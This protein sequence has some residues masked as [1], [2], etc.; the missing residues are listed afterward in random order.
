MTRLTKRLIVAS[1][2]SLSLGLVNNI[3]EA[4]SIST[5]AAVQDSI[6]N[7]R[8][9]GRAIT[10]RDENEKA[11]ADIQQWIE[12]S[13]AELLELEREHVTTDEDIKVMRGELEEIKKNLIALAKERED[14][15]RRLE[16]EQAAAAAAYD[17]AA[18]LQQQIIQL[19]R[20]IEAAQREADR[21]NAGDYNV[22]SSNGMLLEEA[23]EKALEAVQYD[24]NRLEEAEAMA[25][26]M[27]G[28]ENIDNSDDESGTAQAAADSRLEAAIDRFDDAMTR[29]DELN[30][31]VN[32]AEDTMVDY[33]EMLVDID[34]QTAY[35]K[36]LEAAIPDSESYKQEL[37]EYR[38]TVNND[39]AELQRD[40][41][42]LERQL[43][44]V[45]NSLTAVKSMNWYSWHNDRGDK[46]HQLYSG[47]YASLIRNTNTEISLQTGIVND[48]YSF[49]GNS[50]D[51]KHLTDTSLNIAQT[52]PH[53]KYNVI[54][55]L[56]LT[57][58]TGDSEQGDSSV[59]V[60]D[61]LVEYDTFG[62]GRL[63]APAIS[64]QRKIGTEDMWTYNLGY[65]FRGDYTNTSQHN[66]ENGNGINTSIAWQHIEEEWQLGSELIFEKNGDS[67]SDGLDYNDGDNVEFHVT[68]NNKL[69]SQNDL[70]YFY[71]Y[72]NQDGSEYKSPVDFAYDSNGQSRHY[73]GVDF[74]RAF[75]EQRSAHIMLTGMMGRGNSYDAA[76]NTSMHALKRYAM[77]A[78]YEYIID[79]NS[80]ISL[81]IER[82]YLKDKVDGIGYRGNNVFFNYLKTF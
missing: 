63:V 13:E 5:L 73:Y 7:L 26:E 43:R 19:Q 78:G 58:P 23:Y 12:E 69:T 70:A 15:A 21:F 81:D 18:R 9:G 20:E 24:E 44:P 32:T 36:E 54:Y 57:L 38:D 31:I 28:L 41:E 53:D 67:R 52:N 80:S 1:V 35:Q 50:S 56:G 11:L 30:E 27:L 51:A 2:C 3:A 60:I 25:R 61:D 48:S 65:D 59:P 79:N 74:N 37:T 68:Y 46:G 66:V 29:L 47:V 42:D 34:E 17:E 55:R 40:K 62:S 6:N 45:E 72:V 82:F 14:T 39:L 10:N 75:D 71:W 77:R 76:L 4:A 33:Q 64:V 8:S 16:I 49:N 22:Q